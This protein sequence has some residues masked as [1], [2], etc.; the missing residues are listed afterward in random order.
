MRQNLIVLSVM[1]EILNNEQYTMLSIK[2][3][4]VNMFKS[5]GLHTQL[6]C[7]KCWVLKKLSN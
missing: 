6:R 4:S 1:S 5:A 3:N 7:K 2:H